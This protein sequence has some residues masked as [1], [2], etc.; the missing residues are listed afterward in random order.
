MRWPE[1]ATVICNMFLWEKVPPQNGT[2]GK[3]GVSLLI[4]YSRFV[5]LVGAFSSLVVIALSITKVSCLSRCQ[6]PKINTHTPLPT[7]KVFW[8]AV[9]SSCSCSE[10]SILTD[11]TRCQL[12]PVQG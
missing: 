4:R 6:I 8:R 10:F 2:L 1:S 9:L 5:C 7:Q 11:L 3:L 12:A